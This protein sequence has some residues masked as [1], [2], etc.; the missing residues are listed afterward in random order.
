M[1]EVQLLERGERFQPFDLCYS[2][3]LNRQD[4]QVGKRRQVLKVIVGRSLIQRFETHLQRADLVL[5]QPELF[6]QRQLLQ[7]LDCLA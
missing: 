6:Q 1:G 5:P 3:G 7:V 4:F 2:V